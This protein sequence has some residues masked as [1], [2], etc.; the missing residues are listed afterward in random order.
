MLRVHH[1]VEEE[2]LEAIWVLGEQGT[3]SAQAA[4]KACHVR[5]PQEALRHLE[6][7]GL[8]ILDAEAVLLTPEGQ[9]RAAFII[10]RQRLGEV[11]ALEVMG[12]KHLQEK[13]A[14]CEFEHVI[15]TRDIDHICTQLRHPT[16]C[17]DGEPIPAGPCCPDRPPDP[18]PAVLSLDALEPERSGRILYVR[19][20]VPP[21]VRALQ[22]YGILGGVAFEL[23]QRWPALVMKV[24]GVEVALDAEVASDIFILTD[25]DP[26]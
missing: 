5:A 2:L 15:T 10:R 4:L 24:G 9:R 8:V 13:Q 1:D 25:P 20:R 23:R 6:R 14:V 22:S 12:F 19:R 7:D 11:L 3:V 17:P 26:T 21:R 18:R 16:H